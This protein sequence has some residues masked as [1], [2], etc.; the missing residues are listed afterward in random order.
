MSGRV[1]LINGPAGVGKTTIGRTLASLAQN[2]IHIEGDLLRGFIV[3]Q[4]EG[5][6]EGG[7]GYKNGATLASNFIEAGYE[8]VV[9][10]YVFEKPGHVSRFLSFFHLEVPVHLFTLWAPFEV[11]AERERTRPNRKRL[12]SR[13]V[14]CY[15]TIERNLD[16]LGY[17]IDNTQ[18]TPRQVAEIIYQMC[19]K[20]AGLVNR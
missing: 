14:E 11:V 5:A 15:R 19:G 7:L 16:R 12:E 18:G 9:F 3:S 2:G 13:V 17:C 8:L 6:V 20:N 4:I 1:V 10:E